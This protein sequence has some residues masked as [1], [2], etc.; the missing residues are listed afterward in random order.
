MAPLAELHP[1]V[2]MI[3]DTLMVHSEYD[4]CLQNCDWHWLYKKCKIDK[5]AWYP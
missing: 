3:A 2:F 1:V 5:A 4:A